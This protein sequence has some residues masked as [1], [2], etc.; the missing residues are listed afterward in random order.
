VPRECGDH[1][2]DLITGVN[3]F[4]QNHPETCSIYDIK[5]KTAAILKR[6]FKDNEK[7]LKFSQL[8]S[9]TASKVRQT[10]LAFLCPSNQRSKSRYM[11]IDV[12]VRWGSKTL[13]HL[14]RGPEAGIDPEVVEKKLGWLIGYRKQLG[15]WEEI[16]SIT[17]KT[18]SFVRN[19]GIF[20]GCDLELR[21]ILKPLVQTE[22]SKRIYS[23][24]LSFVE[25]ESLK[26]KPNERLPGSSEVIESI[27][28]KLKYLGKSQSTNGF[29][30]LI[31]SIAAM[32][33]KNT[34][35]IVQNAIETVRTKDVLKWCRE[36]LGES[37]QAKRKKAFSDE[38]KT[39]Q[40]W[41]Q[42]VEAV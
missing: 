42:V 36:M 26:A 12:L 7:W 5:H 8:S 14:D 30:G 33:A 4:C 2:S 9:Q 40:K 21:Q 16:L 24:L 11:N 27:F 17:E 31:L 35:D 25:A 37:V 15:E 20:R 19:K 10:S 39:E 38:K 28:G 6:E 3:K 22:Q 13:R 29:T 32:V 1:G 34:R 41:D 23:E 18:E